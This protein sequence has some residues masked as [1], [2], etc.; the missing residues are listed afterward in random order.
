MRLR[1]LGLVLS[2]AAGGQ[3]FGAIAGPIQTKIAAATGAVGS[4]SATLTLT[5]TVGN[6]ILVGIIANA[7]SWPMVL[8]VT[9]NQAGNGNPYARVG[10][11][12]SGNGIGVNNWVEASFFC[13]VANALTGTFIVTANTASALTGFLS[14]LVAEYSGA[15]CNPDQI[16]NDS[17]TSGVTFPCGTLTT[18]NANDLLATIVDVNASG[19]LVFAISPLSYTIEMQVNNGSASQPGAFADQIVT[20]TGTFAPVWTS[21]SSEGNCASVA[22]KA[23]SGGGSGG[24]VAYA[25]GQ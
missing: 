8:K 1:F 7:G 14:V 9:D 20:S 11:S 4:E 17:Q 6:I 24:Q 21:T 13:A 10:S 22:L 2:A 15:S 25:L 12:F 19:T 16:S 5:P 18:T 23:A 3:L